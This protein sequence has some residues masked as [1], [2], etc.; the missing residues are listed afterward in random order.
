MRPFAIG[1]LQLEVPEGDHTDLAIEKI[2]A[3]V[4]RFPW[5]EMVLLSELAVTGMT[6][7]DA[8]PLPGPAEDR[9]RDLARELGV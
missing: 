1:G 5:V 3:L 7:A 6:L 9:L 2:R 8:Q 4:K